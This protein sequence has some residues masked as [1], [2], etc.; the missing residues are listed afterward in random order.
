MATRLQ[1]PHGPCHLITIVVGDANLLAEPQL[2][3]VGQT[4]RPSLHRANRHGGAVDLVEVE[5]LHPE[6]AERRAQ[7]RDN[8]RAAKVP[9]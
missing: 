5:F 3:C 7:V 8:I 4:V 2:E 6:A 9:R 1:D